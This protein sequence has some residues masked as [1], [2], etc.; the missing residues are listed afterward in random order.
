M[1]N[2]LFGDYPK[3]AYFTLVAA[4]SG[5]TFIRAPASVIYFR[6]LRSVPYPNAINEHTVY[7]YFALLSSRRL[8]FEFVV[9]TAAGIS[10]HFDH[11]RR[12][13]LFR[14]SRNGERSYH[15]K[16][17][18]TLAGME[19]K[20]RHH[21]TSNTRAWLAAVGRRRTAFAKPYCVKL[22][23]KSSR[24]T[25]WQPGALAR[26]AERATNQPIPGLQRRLIDRPV[27]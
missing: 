16:R 6:H 17:K 27:A 3:T 7:G 13:L 26:Q 21:S 19:K 25:G 1:A 18:Q 2:Y 10:V 11:T 4:L 12:F 14:K 15:R 22:P 9:C 5:S 8:R 24:L 23:P 20:R